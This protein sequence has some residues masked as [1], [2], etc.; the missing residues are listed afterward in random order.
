MESIKYDTYAGM[1]CP[2]GVSGAFS[3]TRLD[4]RDTGRSRSI[5]YLL[6]YVPGSATVAKTMHEIM[7]LVMLC[8]SLDVG[9]V[10]QLRT[11][12]G[13]IIVVR[14]H[15]E[16]NCLSTDALMDSAWIF[17]N[18]TRLVAPFYDGCIYP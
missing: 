8:H 7:N 15:A 9:S 16:G 17:A 6:N 11:E 4:P 2:V 5:H 18:K 1:H 10:L 13:Y 3:S 14:L 12:R